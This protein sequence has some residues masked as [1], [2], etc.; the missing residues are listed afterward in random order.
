MVAIVGVLS[1]SRRACRGAKTVFALTAVAE[2]LY[3]LTENAGGIG[4]PLRAV[5]TFRNPNYPGH[6]LALGLV[7]VWLTT[8]PRSLRLVLS[9][10]IALAIPRTGS[11]G[12]LVLLYAAVAYA[13]W[14]RIN[15]LDARLRFPMRLVAVAPF[16]VLTTLAI[17]YVEQPSVDLGSGLSAER[18]ERSSNQRGDLYHEGIRFALEHPLGVGPSGVDNRGFEEQIGVGEFHSDILDG[19]ANGGLIGFV[20][21]A[22]VIGVL[23]R[24]GGPGSSLRLVLVAAM[25]SSLTRQT[26]NFRH[27]WMMLAIVAAE[28]IL[29]QRQRLRTT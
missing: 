25:A 5:G 13:L 23:W 16:V 9:I 20:G 7:M 17:G 22:G 15:R 21:M 24:L 28:A 3:L 19:F 4:E 29:D 1:T 8:W 2:A 27:L 14:A 12:A 10:P 6:F 26:W 11:F 18:L